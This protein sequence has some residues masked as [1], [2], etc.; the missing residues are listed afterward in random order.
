MVRTLLP[1]KMRVRSSAHQS[2][3]NALYLWP[4]S[5]EN[6][7]IDRFHNRFF[8]RSAWYFLYPS[9][10]NWP[11]QPSKNRLTKLPAHSASVCFLEL[12]SLKFLETV[13][14]RNRRKNRRHC[15]F[16]TLQYICWHL[17][18]AGHFQFIVFRYV[19]Y[20]YYLAV[21]MRCWKVRIAWVVLRELTSHNFLSSALTA[22]WLR[23]QCATSPRTQVK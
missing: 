1:R 19:Q 16:G 7:I 17:I 21:P 18:R 23:Q 14:Q 12:S 13:T 4:A 8:S 20:G 9:Y 2:F 15:P 10:A 22:T 3:G 6:H 11:G 5:M